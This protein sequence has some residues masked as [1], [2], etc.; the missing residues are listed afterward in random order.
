[1]VD[2]SLLNSWFNIDR[3]IELP[4]RYRDKFGSEFVL[5]KFFSFAQGEGRNI[6]IG[7]LGGYQYTGRIEIM[8]FGDF[9]GKGEY[10]WAVT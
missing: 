1:M 4:L 5:M 2:R 9:K 6:S 3:D 8:P 7:N 10:M